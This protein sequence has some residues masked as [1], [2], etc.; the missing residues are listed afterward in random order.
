MSRWNALRSWFR[1][2]VFRSRVDRDLNE[3][4]RFHVEEE[5]AAGLR[6]GLTADEARRAAYASLGGAPATIRDQCHDQRGISLVEDF[7]RDLKYGVRLLLRNPTFSAVVFLTLAIA[8]GATVTVF[9]IVDAW[10]VK[11]LNFPRSDRLVIAFAAQPE[12]PSEPAVWLPYRAYLALKERSR[13]LTAVSA[14]FVRNVTVTR[15]TDAQTV[16]GLAVSPEFF[17]TFGV[18]PLL[19]RPVSD[20]DR[21]GSPVVVLSYGYWQRQ[22]GGSDRVIGTAVMMSGVPHEVVGVMPRDFEVRVLDMRFDFWTALRGGDAGYEPGGTGPVAVIGRLQD[23]TTIDTARSEVAAIVRET[24]AQY[25]QNFNRLVANLSSLQADNTR[26][27]RAT[28]VTISTAVLCLLLIAAM[29]VGTLLIGQ[30]LGR[31]R[32]AAIRAAMGCGRSRLVRQFLTESLVLALL[33]GI[34]GLALAAVAVRLFVAWNP[35]GALP[36]NAIQ[37]DHRALITAALAVA[38]TTI[39]AGLLPALRVSTADPNDALRPGGQRGTVAEVP[40]QRAQTTLLVAQ[41]AAC[42]VLLVA[43]VLMIR[44]FARLQNEPLG[45]RADNLF[46][47]TV[48]VPND[49]FD[50]SEKRNLYYRQ[51]ADRLRAFPG[52]RAVAAGTSPPLNSG[53]PLL[54]NTGAE[55]SPDAPRISGQEVTNAFFDTL[56]TPVLAGRAFDERDSATFAPAVILNA[57]AAQDLFGG[58]TK[59]IGQR[60]R[61]NSEPWREVVGVVGNVRSTFFNTLEWRMDP[62]VYRPAAQAFSMLPNPTATSFGFSLYIRSDGRLTI[63]DVRT[64]AAAVNPR[65]AVTELQPVSAVVRQATSQPAFRMTLLVWFAAASLLL[66]AIGMYGVVSQTVIQRLPE[67]AI[68]LALGAEPTAVLAAIMRRAMAAAGAGLAIGAVTAL[69]LGRAL[70]G[71]LYGVRPRDAMSFLAAGLILLAVAIVGAFVPARR[72]TRV[73]PLKVLRAD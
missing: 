5:I 65:A 33:G 16:L 30:G 35:L 42:V 48:M 51:L 38:A 66:A 36:A 26:T 67:I 61:L 45:F 72:A 39:V 52:V 13:I 59:A 37:L 43:T 46:V 2:L 49:P 8:L 27:V 12:R 23:Q 69:V 34:A 28:L 4:L 68:R 71:L 56:Q 63:A 54:V 6:A 7:T 44:T 62:I 41:V 15:G 55:D 40:A 10:L 57:R 17:R 22:F 1:S 11:P 20:S 25:Q 47:A 58:A 64:A 31:M 3:E 21:T 9:S 60:L 18:G 70:E 19:G 50:S 29:N 14:A 32:E 24:E 73:D 53:V